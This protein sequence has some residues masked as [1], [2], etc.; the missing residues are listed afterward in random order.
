MVTQGRQALGA[1]EPRRAA[2]VL[3][4]SLALWRGSALAD[5]PPSA[6]VTAEELGV[7]PGAELQQLYQAMLTVGRVPELRRREADEPAASPRAE[8]GTAPAADTAA[9]AGAAGPA[10]GPAA[11]PAAARPAAVRSPAPAQLPADVADFTGRDE[12]VEQLHRLL[13][14][15]QQS[16]NPAALAV[17]VLAGAGGVGKTALAVHAATAGARRRPPITWPSATGSSGG[18]RTRWRRC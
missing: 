5:V 17:A 18:M 8:A 9:A 13:S 10:P 6:L 7:D 4:E 14:Q 16:D 15:A 11:A 2:M 1:G 12:R 3:A